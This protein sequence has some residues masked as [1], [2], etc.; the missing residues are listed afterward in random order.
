MV[1]GPPGDFILA[2]PPHVL[3][4]AQPG[5]DPVQ[6]PHSGRPPGDAFVQADDHHPAARRALGVQLL[7]LVDQLLLVGSRVEAGE[8]ELAMSSGAPCTA[9]W[10]TAGR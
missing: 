2:R 5:Q 1:K 3:A 9:L 7:E 4:L 6:H 10:R 8:I